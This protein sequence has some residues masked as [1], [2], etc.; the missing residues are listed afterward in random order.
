MTDHPPIQSKPE[1]LAPPSWRDD[2]N[3]AQ[4]AKAIL[5]ASSGELASELQARGWGVD[6]SV[7]RSPGPTGTLHGLP[8]VAIAQTLEKRLGRQVVTYTAEAK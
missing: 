6:N 4:P 2:P 8:S 3:H 7:K 5:R 1:P